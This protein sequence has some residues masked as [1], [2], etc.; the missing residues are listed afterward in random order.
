[1]ASLSWSTPGNVHVE[2]AGKNM[3]V[4]QKPSGKAVIMAQSVH[5]GVIRF[6]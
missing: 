1:M 5:R 3:I 6:Q 4:E 2:L